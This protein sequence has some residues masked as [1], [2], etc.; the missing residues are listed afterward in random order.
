MCAKDRSLRISRAPL[1]SQAHQGTSLF[2][3]TKDID[4]DNDLISWTCASY[5]SKVEEVLSLDWKAVRIDL[6]PGLK[7]GGHFGKIAGGK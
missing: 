6:A 4:K 5:D 2:T 7:Q 1:K 3:S